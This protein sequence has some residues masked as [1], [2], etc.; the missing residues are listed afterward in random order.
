MARAT[1]PFAPF[2]WLIALR[3]LRPK[4][5]QGAITLI[6]IISLL[7][8]TAG[9]AALI[10][11]MSVMNGFRAELLSRI[12]GLNG[13]IIVQNISAGLPNYDAV[14]QKIR[15]VPGVTDTM[16]IVEG[17]V[18][19][20]TD[21]STF[22]A[23]TRG[24]R[25]SDFAALMARIQ[26]SASHEPNGAN[27]RVLSDGALEHFDDG[28]SVVV[29]YRLAEK[30]GVVPGMTVTLIAPKGQVTPFGMTPRV[31][32]YRV[33]GTFN[34]GMSQY[35]ETFIYMPLA[36]S[37]LYFSMGDTVG[38]IEVMV[39]DPD[40]VASLREVVQQAAGP[41]I[42]VLD[43]QDMSANL[44]EALQVEA[45]AMFFILSIIVGVA[46]LNIISSL[47][48]MVK[49]KSGDIAILRTMGASRGAIMRVFLI[50]GASVGVLG[51][52]VG[53]LIGV[54]F[55]QYIEPIRQFVAGIAG[56]D[57]F[58]PMVYFL[59]QLP[60][61]MDVRDVIWVVSLSL[62]L[63]FIATLYPSWRAARLDPVEALRYE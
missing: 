50:A 4:R 23:L 21:G 36:E 6:A 63:S 42:R 41:K 30:L 13:H 43:W 11:V 26:E 24:M 46:A 2:E 17:Q 31:K 27:R 35:D 1:H 49:D 61:K 47:I 8:I 58:N 44:F 5:K 7:G 59:S 53:M 57:V 55:C 37:Q 56:K 22:G 29:G 62:G 3:Y 40:E 39:T 19:V 10:I 16:P 9:V 60:A 54:L 34:I 32:S 38:G 48:M 51:T 20:S 28:Q 14:A 52:V 12:L 18:I 45:A 25:K 33:A 15:A